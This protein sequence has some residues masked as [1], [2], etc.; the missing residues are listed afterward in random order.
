MDNPSAPH[1]LGIHN[2]R[3]IFEEIHGVQQSN[4]IDHPSRHVT[5]HRYWTPLLLS[6]QAVSSP[7][8]IIT[9]DQSEFMIKTGKHQIDPVLENFLSKTAKPIV[10]NISQERYSLG[11]L[12]DGI[13]FTRKSGS[14]EDYKRDLKYSV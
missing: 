6:P 1:L 11:R 2:C 14:L 8:N 5:P 12:K 13:I 3:A 9:V 4:L 7:I 10:G